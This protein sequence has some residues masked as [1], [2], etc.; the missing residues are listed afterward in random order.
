MACSCAIGAVTNVAQQTDAASTELLYDNIENS[1]ENQMGSSFGLGIV[2]TLAAALLIG[3]SGASSPEGGPGSVGGGASGIPA[4]GASP[5]GSQSVGGSSTVGG[6]TATNGGSVAS[7]TGGRVASGGSAVSGGITGNGGL[8]ASGGE[9]GKGGTSGSGGTNTNGG[10]ATSG[11]SALVGGSVGVGG[12][13]SGGSAANGGKSSG[14]VGAMGGAAAKGGAGG[15]SGANGGAPTGGVGA[16]GGTAATG[17]SSGGDAAYVM[18]YFTESPNYSEAR[19]ALHLAYSYDGLNYVPLNQN[20][21]VVT[22]TQGALGLR[23][24]FILRKQDGTFVVIATNMKGI[25]MAGNLSKYIHVWD[26]TD[27]LRTFSNYRLL[28]VNNSTTMHAWAPEAFWDSSKSQYAVVW[29]G[30]TDRNR[31]YVSYTTDFKTVTDFN[32][33]TVYHD[34]GYT[35]YDGDMLMY[36]GVNYFYNANG[37]IY[38]WKSNSLTPKSFTQY[39]PS[40]A[41]SGAAIEAPTLV[42]KLGA[43]V[44]WLWGD[45]YAPYNALFYVWQTTDIS[46]NSWKLLDRREYEGPPNG[47]HNTIC[48]VTLAELDN[49]IAKWGNPMWQ[50]IKSYSKPDSFIRHANNVGR[51]DVS[52]VDPMAD[53][54]WKVVPGLADSA[55]ISFESV[56]RANYYLRNSNNS[57][58]LNVSDNSA[59]FRESA[60]FYRVEGLANTSWTSFR[61]YADPSRYIRQS[62]NVLK[63]D[64]IAT[65]TDRQDATFKIFYEAK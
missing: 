23:D 46:T 48:K 29:A 51:I 53:S 18:G 16:S 12:R 10:S 9:I 41:P 28:Q 34:P 14:G 17:G 44:F 39:V 21:P 40:L 37:Q 11:G 47:K 55:G 25:D 38:G 32:T 63:I 35:I 27:G 20:T 62:S 64:P 43:N 54:K 36:N 52:V 59:A 19:Y 7:G 60:T 58:V 42:Q 22:P 3:C 65:D 2:N 33:L 57:V 6:L 49:L 4:G 5:G 50:R 24:P 13:A 1:T 56:S 30:N 45:S 15:G 61:S 31:L 8:D 26:S